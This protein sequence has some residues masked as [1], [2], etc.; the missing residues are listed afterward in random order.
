MRGPR[1]PATCHDPARGRQRQFQ[2]RCRRRDTR[3]LAGAVPRRSGHVPGKARE[4]WCRWSPAGAG[5]RAGRATAGG[6]RYPPWSQP[7]WTPEARI[8]PSQAGKR[9]LC[10]PAPV[11]PAPPPA[12]RREPASARQPWPR[13]GTSRLPQPPF[14][15][16]RVMSASAGDRARQ[17]ASGTSTVPRPACRCQNVSTSADASSTRYG[18]Q[19]RHEKAHWRADAGLRHPEVAPLLR[20]EFIVGQ[21]MPG[22]PSFGSG[23]RCTDLW[24]LESLDIRELQCSMRP[25]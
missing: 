3:A 16:S 5:G 18:P 6:R 8:R 25:N 7:R 4:G 21:N 19:D 12:D 15:D 2:F 22:V 24:R 9:S 11:H 20:H 23:L 17:G 1:R 10:G 13:T 14:R